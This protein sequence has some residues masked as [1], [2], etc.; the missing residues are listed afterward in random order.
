[1]TGLS[2][3]FVT[4]VSGLPRSGT[5]MMMQM[6]AAGGLA[7]LTDQLRASDEDNLKGY[8]EFEPVKSTNRDASWVSEA[9]GKAV[10]VVYMLLK[11]LP[12]EHQYRV[13]FMRRDL[14]EVVG[15]QQAML[16]RRGEPGAQLAKHEM[17]AIFARQL[18]KTDEWL[19]LQPNFQVLDVG[20]REVVRDPRGE[21]QHVCKFLALPLDIDAM[22]AAV[23]PALYRQRANKIA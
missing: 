3:P 12:P 17:A 2:R 22:A 14:G 18:E 6:L 1:M 11:D 13:I 16:A 23:D 9:V 4:I 19:Q 7:V 15:S 10:K 5:S 20:Y 8:L 21:G